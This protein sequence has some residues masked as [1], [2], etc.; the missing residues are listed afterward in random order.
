[1]ESNVTNKIFKGLNIKYHEVYEIVWQV[2]I[3]LIWRELCVVKWGW[4]MQWYVQHAYVS[5]VEIHHPEVGMQPMGKGRASIH[6]ESDSH[7]MS[8][9]S[10]GAHLWIWQLLMDVGCHCLSYNGHGC[11]VRMSQRWEGKMLEDIVAH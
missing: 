2:I 11:Q 6:G 9:A 10:F 5:W 3:D 7:W 1:M 8:F 4:C